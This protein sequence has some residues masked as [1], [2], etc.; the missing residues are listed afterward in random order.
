MA[1]LLKET[2]R[3][4]NRPHVRCGDR[5]TPAIE[6]AEAAVIR[7]L[8]DA[9]RWP[10]FGSSKVTPARDARP[11]VC[12]SPL[13]CRVAVSREWRTSTQPHVAP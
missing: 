4:T 13:S 9:I 2:V 7:T 10:A 11:H 12:I 6:E 1:P 8:T 5:D 3:K